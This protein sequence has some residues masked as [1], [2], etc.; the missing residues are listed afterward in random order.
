MKKLEVS[1]TYLQHF[2]LQKIIYDIILT[3][4][5]KRKR[6]GGG[7]GSYSVR[8]RRKKNSK[9]R[10]VMNREKTDWPFCG[11]DSVASNSFLK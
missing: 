2:K 10:K 1:D 11:S 4:Y 5:M 9:R 3:I 8:R 6:G 7:G